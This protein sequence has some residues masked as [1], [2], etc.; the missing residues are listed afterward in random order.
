MVNS[1]S[2][3]RNVSSVRR[4]LHI[5]THKDEDPGPAVE[6]TD[7]LHLHDATSEKTAEGTSSSG[8]REEDGH[9]KTAFVT[10]VPHG[11][12]VD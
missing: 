6:A 2:Y 9:A 5:F 10:P 1:P 8:G 4:T 3:M 12:A 11:D 7:T